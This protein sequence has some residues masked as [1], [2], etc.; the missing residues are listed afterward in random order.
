MSWACLGAAI[1]IGTAVALSR[2]LANLLFGV[3][4]LDP[5][6]FFGVP[7]FLITVLLLAVWIHSRRAIRT[8]LL[9]ALRL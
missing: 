4:V 2:F 5:L 1:G 8:D 6:I 9:V 7:L 3:R